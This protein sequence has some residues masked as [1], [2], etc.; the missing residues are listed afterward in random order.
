MVFQILLMLE[1][2]RMECLFPHDT[3]FWMAGFVQVT[4]EH[5]YLACGL[6]GLG[7]IQ[8][9]RIAALPYLRSGQLREVLPQWKSMP[10]NVSVAFVKSRQAAPRVS[11]FVDWLA[12]LFERSQ[13][14]DDTL[15]RLFR[16]ARRPAHAAVKAAVSRPGP[17]TRDEDAHEETTSE[18]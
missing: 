6:Q 14:M 12:E 11:A 1:R 7:L 10:M 2:E 13:E 17:A 3:P 4:D 16:A 5:A 18:S 9:P 15:T 8:P